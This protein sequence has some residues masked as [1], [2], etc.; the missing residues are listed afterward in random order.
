MFLRTSAWFCI[1]VLLIVPSSIYAAELGPGEA[2]ELRGNLTEPTQISGVTRYG[3]LLVV[4]PDEGCEFD[5]L[6]PDGANA[7]RATRSVS[8]CEDEDEPK[9]EIDLEG[10]ASDGDYLFLVGSHSLARHKVKPDGEYGQNRLRL[11]EIKEDSSR[12]AVFRLQLG[13]HGKLKSKEKINLRK[14]LK[15]DDILC[16]FTEIPSKENGIDIEGVAARGSKLYLG[17][18]GP[19]LRGNYVPVMVLDFDS[20]KDYELKFVNLGGRGIRDIA[21]VK[22]GL[23]IIAGP[24]GEDSETYELCFWNDK[25]C[26]PGVGGKEGAV[27]VLGD[28]LPRPGAKA[29]GLN[30]LDEDERRYTIL[31]VYDGADRGGATKFL[32]TKPGN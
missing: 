19:V 31:V 4:C 8:L 10:A 20:P 13:E 1:V 14:I 27:S 22:D 21:A 17:F 28:F 23:L 29:E 32:V 30:V 9:E 18:R 2:I 12:D 16:R 7:Y 26:I 3:D 15:N 24:V 6:V 5:V 25:D 11:A